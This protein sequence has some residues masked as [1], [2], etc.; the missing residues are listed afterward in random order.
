MQQLINKGQ[1]AVHNQQQQPHIHALL[2]SGQHSRVPV[3]GHHLSQNQP[4]CI[5]R[6]CRQQLQRAAD[7]II[8]PGTA[9]APA[10][11]CESSN[12]PGHSCSCSTALL[13]RSRTYMQWN[14]NPT[15]I[16]GM[17][18]RASSHQRTSMYQTT[19]HHMKSRVLVA[20]I[21]WTL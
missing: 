13:M 9:A 21:I 10:A 6:C 7:H 12:H 3:E 14:Y 1:T 20:A 5:C 19:H 8:N 17:L 15:Q 18:W 16:H 11:C 2:R 4:R